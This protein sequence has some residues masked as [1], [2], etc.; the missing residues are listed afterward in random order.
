MISFER[1][2]DGVPGKNGVEQMQYHGRVREARE[3]ACLLKRAFFS[4]NFDTNAQLRSPI[5]RKLSI[6]GKKEGQNH[7]TVSFF[8]SFGTDRARIRSAV[9]EK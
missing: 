7:I 3:R 4:P 6:A 1:Q 2:N 8:L 9:F 5:S